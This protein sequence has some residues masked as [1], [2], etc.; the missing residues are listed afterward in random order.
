HPAEHPALHPGR[1]AR[2]RVGDDDIGH[3]G[4]L[5]PGHARRLGVGAAVYLLELDLAALAQ[6]ELPR[7]AAISRYP[8]V[9]RDL[10]VAVDAAVEARAVLAAARAAAGEWLTELALFDIYQGAQ[11]APDQKGFAF[12][13]TFQ[14]QSSN[15]A[16]SEVDA[17]IERII[18]ALQR[19]FAAELRTR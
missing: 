14:S 4:Q 17:C 8:A 18:S 13:L 15:L 1:G 6:A 2:I 11:L 7:F 12:G 9:R 19:D 10:A 16:S 3:L 5:H